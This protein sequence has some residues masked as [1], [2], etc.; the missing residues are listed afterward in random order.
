M[1]D[2]HSLFIENGQSK[3]EILGIQDPDFVLMDIE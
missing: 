1:M 3:I 2:N